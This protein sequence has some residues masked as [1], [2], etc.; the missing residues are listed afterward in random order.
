MNILQG[1]YKWVTAPNIN[2]IKL[3][4]PFKLTYTDITESIC[5]SMPGMHVSDI[6]CMILFGS[7]VKSPI[8]IKCVD[9]IETTIGYKEIDKIRWEN[10]PNDIDILL[11]TKGIIKLNKA[12]TD[13]KTTALDIRFLSDG[14]SRKKFVHCRK[15]KFHFFITNEEEFNK[16]L[17][18]G[19][20]E[21]HSIVKEGIV[22]Y[23]NC[24]YKSL[25]NM[26]EARLP[27]RS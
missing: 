22:M 21:A 9:R 2:N 27:S 1:W 25:Y 18:E 5:N 11:L 7:C 16:Y 15:E 8:Y 19:I 20:S 3:N 24:V 17:K 23:G 13:I 26:A 4:L 14:Y 6:K 12:S 10:K